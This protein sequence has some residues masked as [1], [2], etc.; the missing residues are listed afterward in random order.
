MGKSIGV[1]SLKGGVGKT[2]STIC[3][4]DALAGFGKKVL[5][6]DGNL[7]APNLGLHLNIIDPKITLHHVLNGQANVSDAIYNHPNFDVLPSQIFNN[8]RINPYR[9]RDKLNS[10][11]KDYDFILIDSS[12]SLSD[13]TLSAMLA[14]DEL[15]VVTTPDLPTLTMTIKAIS[16][17]KKREAPISGI[18]LN[19]VYNKKFEIPIRK[20]EEFSGVPVVARIPHDVEILKA[21]S[22]FS[23]YTQHRPNSKGAI[24]FKKLAATISG[25]KYK[26][27]TWKEV[28][29]IGPSKT[30]V[31]RQLYYSRVFR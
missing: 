18:I 13:E 16:A 28:L 20:I 23:P 6:V 1:I 5:L 2:S 10:L 29:R 31:N 7:S 19:K 12:P 17:A 8:Q 26:P 11:K 14:S 25:E 15:F 22:E 9:L 21:V 27:F 4:G 24:E 3:L 30:D